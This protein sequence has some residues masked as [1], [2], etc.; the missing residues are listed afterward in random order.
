[1]RVT[2]QNL[3]IALAVLVAVAGC[4]PGSDFNL[5]EVS[6]TVTMNG[7]PMPNVHVI[8]YPKATAENPDSGPYSEGTTDAAGKFSMTTRYG[9]PGSVIGPNRVEF[10]YADIDE[11]MLNAAEEEQEAAEASGIEADAATISASKEMQQK[12]K[13]RPNIPAKY[14]S[15]SELEFVVP[16]EGTTTADFDLGK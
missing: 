12:L 15:D 4:Q 7:E 3:A 13:N 6:G 2:L 5:A 11:E 9:N 10:E 16:K 14:G 1:M 8:F